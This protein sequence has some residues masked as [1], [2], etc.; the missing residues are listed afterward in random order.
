M[1][2]D[3]FFQTQASGIQSSG[4]HTVVH[5]MPQMEPNQ[6]KAKKLSLLLDLNAFLGYRWQDFIAGACVAASQWQGA[7]SGV[8]GS[9]GTLQIS[10][11]S[12]CP[13]NNS[14]AVRSYPQG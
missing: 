5:G 13:D 9:N 12:I 1:S 11:E 2:D 8:L 14:A 6:T 7:G 10:V 3:G 4:E